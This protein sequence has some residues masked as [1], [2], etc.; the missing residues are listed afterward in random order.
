MQLGT[1][2]KKSCELWLFLQKN[3][4]LTRRAFWSAFLELKQFVL[5]AFSLR[6]F[7]LC[8]LWSPRR[9]KQFCESRQVISAW[10]FRLDT[11]LDCR[12]I[13]DLDLVLEQLTNRFLWNSNGHGSVTKGFLSF[14]KWRYKKLRMIS[15]LIWQAFH[16]L[17]TATEKAPRP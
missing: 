17:G 16:R 14:L 5:S 13:F 12:K 10:R 3:L 8:Y 6:C 1:F 7:S 2:T 15:K 9:I 11:N 4:H